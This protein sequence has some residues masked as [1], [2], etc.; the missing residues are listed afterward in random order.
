MTCTEDQLSSPYDEHAQWY[1][2]VMRASDFVPVTVSALRSML[3]AP[4]YIDE[5]V[6]DLGCGTGLI[7]EGLVREGWQVT[8]VDSSAVMLELAK[9]RLS[10]TVHASVVDTGLPSQSTGVVMS[11]WTHTDVPWPGLVTE[12]YRLLR[13]GGWFV[14]VGGDPA[15]MP[16]PSPDGVRARVGWKKLSYSEVLDPLRTS[17][18][19]WDHVQRSSF[20]QRLPLLRIRAVKR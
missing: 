17:W 6:V 7:S 5:S 14:Y 16:E 12:A 18:W 19:W 10:H 4:T 9:P 3:L 11:T 2:E 15:A 20:E 8:G 13:P 1:D